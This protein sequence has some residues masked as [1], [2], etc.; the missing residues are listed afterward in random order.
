[1][2]DNRAQIAK[3]RLQAAEAVRTER[4]AI[5]RALQNFVRPTSLTYEETQTNADARERRLLE[6]TA[7]R[8]LEL[9]ASFLLSSVFVAG[10]GNQHSFTFAVEGEERP[11][12]ELKAWLERA[13]KTLRRVMFSGKYGAIKTLHKVCLDLG[14]Y[15]TAAFGAWENTNPRRPFAPVSF[16][17]YSVWQTAGECDADGEVCAVYLRE[18]LSARAAL[19]RFPALEGH[20]RPEEEGEQPYIFAAFSADDPEVDQ[21]ISPAVREQDGAWYGIWISEG[22]GRVLA[23]AAYPEQPI[24]LPAWYQVDRTVWGR[25]PAMTAL[26]DIAMVNNLSELVNRGTE[27][28]VDP[29]YEV[30]DGALLSP[31]RLYPG[32]LTYTDGNEGLRPLIP[33]GASRIEIGN[34]LLRDRMDRIER[35]FFVHLFQ[36]TQNPGGSK[37]PRTATEVLQDEDERNRAVAPMVLNMQ[38]VMIEPLLWRVLGLLTRRGILPVPPTEL[39]G[40]RII[41]RHSS[42]VVSSQQQIEAASIMRWV[43]GLAMVANATANPAILDWVDV[44]KVAERLHGGSG[45]PADVLRG[46]TVVEALRQTR[47]QQQAIAATA[48]TAATGAQA[49]ASLSKAAQ[50]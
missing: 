48:E 17:H 7:A 50:Q 44:D 30:R 32:G 26:G 33:P 47:A 34:E 15:G 9:F 14:L 31:L 29:P 1:M 24:Y 39:N 42:P 3:R 22:D 45:A 25:S 19:K 41:V 43:E 20:L 13:V 21:L 10:L 49:L 28:L 40:R 27:K 6:S 5:W 46:R 36:A 12:P 38:A 16:R 23:E 37:Q 8:S 4:E 35:A 11:G 2:A 18:K